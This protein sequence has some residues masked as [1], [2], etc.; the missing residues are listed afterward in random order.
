MK[1]FTYVS[2]EAVVI[3]SLTGGQGWTGND[4]LENARVRLGELVTGSEAYHLEDT[5]ED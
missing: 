1:T 4:W 5:I 2:P 3:F